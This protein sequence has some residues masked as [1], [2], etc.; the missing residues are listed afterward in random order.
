MAVKIEKAPD[1]VMGEFD[2]FDPK[3][4]YQMVPVGESRRGF[5]ITSDNEEVEAAFE[6]SGIAKFSTRSFQPPSPLPFGDD[7]TRLAPKT[8]VKFEIFGIKAG[9]TTLTV[10]NSQGKALGTLLVSVKKQVSKTYA[11]C[12]LS[13]M[14]RTCP[15]PIAT[16]RPMMQRVEKTFL[17]QANIKLTEKN[18]QIYE[19][20]V[21]DRDLGDP[22][23]PERIIQP[24]NVRLEHYILF[25]RSPTAAILVDFTVFFAWDLK[26]PSAKVEIVGQN[27]GQ[28]CF[29]EFNSGDPVDNGMVTAHEIGHGL[30]LLHSSANTL[31]AGDGNRRS[32]RLQQFEIDM[33]NQTDEQTTP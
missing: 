7:F 28:A 2:G 22:L 5:S 9:N 20:N 3:K 14:R 8:T 32:S 24:E 6:P 25:K 23:I 11:L 33:I 29:V 21:N 31:M 19:V 17:Q 12:R 10:K 30:G 1:P 4:L 16:L 18:A 27:F 13:D 26:A 15:W